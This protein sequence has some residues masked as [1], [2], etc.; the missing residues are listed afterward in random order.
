MNKTAGEAMR[1]TA[2]ARQWRL[3]MSFGLLLV[4]G[5]HLWF[6]RDLSFGSGAPLWLHVI[7]CGQTAGWSFE[8]LW[9]TR[10]VRRHV[11]L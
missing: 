3:I 2:D 1:E 10:F 11:Q 8:L 9:R 7:A 5:T 4:A 6:L